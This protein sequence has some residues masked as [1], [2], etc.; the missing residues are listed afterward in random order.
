MKVLVVDAQGKGVYGVT[1]SLSVAV[2]PGGAALTGTTVAT[3]G[4]NGIAIFAS[5]NLNKVGIGYVLK[6]T[7]N[8]AGAGTALSN[9]FSV[10]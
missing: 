5:N 2:N 10:R 7:T 6:A 3:T 1:V 4:N 8:L 9:P